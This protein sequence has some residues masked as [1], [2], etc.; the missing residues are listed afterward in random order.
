LDLSLVSSGQL[1]QLV[2]WS[3]AARQQHTDEKYAEY[4]AGR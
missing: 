2:E 1:L 4:V 3:L